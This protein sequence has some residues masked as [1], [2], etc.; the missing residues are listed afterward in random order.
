VSGVTRK[1]VA[2]VLLDLD[3]W[4]RI[5]DSLLLDEEKKRIRRLVPVI[6]DYA[7]GRPMRAVLR[8]VK[9]SRTQLLRAFGRCVT[10]HPDGQLYGWRGLLSGAARKPY[11]R[12]QP[13]TTASGSAGALH[14][15]FRTMPGLRDRLTNLVLK[16]GRGVHEARISNKELHKAF[17]DECRL[18][19]M[20]ATQ[21]PF[22]ARHLGRRSIDRFMREVLI[23]HPERAARSRYGEVAASK[24]FTGTG[25]DRL[26]LAMAPFDVAEM[27]GHRIDMI[28]GV[29]IPTPQGV[30]WVPIERLQLLIIADGCSGAIIG[31]YAVVRRECRS[32]D[33][34]AAAEHLTIPWQPR[35]LRVPG[36]AYL[37]GAGLPLGVVPGLSSCAFAALMVDNALINIGFAVT[38]RLR[39]RLGCAVNWGPVRKWMRRPLIERINRSLEQ[40]GFQRVVST[41]GSHPKDPRREDPEQVAV[42]HCLG[43]EELLDLIDV[44]I[45]NYNATSSEGHFSL[46][47]LEV[48]AQTAS[49]SACATLLPTLP[50]ANGLRA[51]LNRHVFTATV[52]GSLEKG[53]R[54]AITFERGKYTNK[55]LAR[56][57]GLVGKKLLL[58]V[59]PSDIRV[60][61]VYLAETGESLGKVRVLGRWR[62]HPHSLELRRQINRAIADKRLVVPDGLDPVTAMHN[63]LKRRAAKHGRKRRPT[64]SAD[65]TALAREWRA[66]GQPS[67]PVARPPLLPSPPVRSRRAPSFGRHL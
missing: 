59:D 16:R 41:T 62:R 34:L 17:I 51:E 43:L 52:R 30:V 47:P 19:G 53:C 4:P 3:L 15:L 50:P 8:D 24:L 57:F 1:T 48:L 61:D 23:A 5:D 6:M 46:S 7:L 2:A 36:M 26:M 39:S 20:P 56:D 21:W 18:A 55:V 27:D 38:D 11:V 28:G 22:T 42:K 40:A 44:V 33:I 49:G 35:A 10:F 54:P 58:H 29:G 9:L 37:N 67:G 64:V 13:A 45:A 65:A 31:Y 25:E 63:A 14:Q 66:T 60:L 12:S 32:S